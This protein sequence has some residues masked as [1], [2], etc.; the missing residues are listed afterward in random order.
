[1]KP[2]SEFRIALQAYRKAWRF[3][4]H[5]K[6]RIFLLIPII[7]NILLLLGGYTL[8]SNLVDKLSEFLFELTGAQNWTFWGSE[9]FNELLSSL[10]H[11]TFKAL[12]ILLMLLYGG[13]LVIIIM[14]PLFSMLSERVEVLATGKS[15]PFTLKKL[16]Q[17]VWRGIRIALRNATLQLLLSILIFLLGFVPIAGILAPFLLFVTSSFFYGFSFIDFAMERRYPRLSESVAFM[18]KHRV[19]AFTNGAI[20]ALSLLL[21]LCNLFLA[22][23]VSIWA[24]IAGTLTLLKIENLKNQQL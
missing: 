20:F 18:R 10:L 4:W 17:D 23:F 22:A 7:I 5:R 13:F 3:L 2:V 19:A 14:S 9:Y 16:L 12:F 1:M 15:Y 6:V 21:P 11:F 24:V 8:L